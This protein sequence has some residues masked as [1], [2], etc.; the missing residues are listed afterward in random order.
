MIVVGPHGLDCRGQKGVSLGPT[1]LIS[2]TTLVRVTINNK[3]CKKM[4]T[5]TISH[6]A[7]QR[8]AM[9]P[10]VKSAS[11]KIA[12]SDLHFKWLA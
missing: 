7:V 4:E 8:A 1:A 5:R 10:I 9:M 11:S 3:A 12:V 6:R 2:Q